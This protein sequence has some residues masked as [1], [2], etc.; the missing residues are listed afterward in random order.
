[1]ATQ[2]S[3]RYARYSVPIATPAASPAARPAAAAASAPT[4]SA[5]AS[6]YRAFGRR[7]ATAP[8]PNR[9]ADPAAT[10]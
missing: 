5:P 9:R 1:M 8:C 7:S 3:T 2:I 4:R 10:Q 6:A